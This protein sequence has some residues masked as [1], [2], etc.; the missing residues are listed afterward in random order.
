MFQTTNQYIC[1]YNVYINMFIFIFTDIIY[2]YILYII[3]IY[4]YMDLLEEPPKKDVPYRFP[5]RSGFPME[6][7]SQII[8]SANPRQWGFPKMVDPKSSP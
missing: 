2:I 5:S 6:K 7:I 1:I 4:I 3:C 8:D